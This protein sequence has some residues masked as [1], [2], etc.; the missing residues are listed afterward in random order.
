MSNFIYFPKISEALGIPDHPI[1]DDGIPEDVI[2]TDSYGGWDEELHRNIDWKT[3]NNHLETKKRK[4]EAMMGKKNPMYGKTHTPES[5]KKISEAMKGNSNGTPFQKENVPW[6]KGKIGD[7]T[8]PHTLYMRE[9]R[10]RKHGS[11]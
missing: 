3:I 5:R 4:S 1:I 8:K 7:S 9:Y 6:N 11:K 10:K 2:R